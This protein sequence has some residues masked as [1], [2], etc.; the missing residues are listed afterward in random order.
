MTMP[1]VDLQQITKKWHISQI[2]VFL[3]NSE[4]LESVDIDTLQYKDGNP[5]SEKSL[6]NLPRIGN[7]RKMAIS[8]FLVPIFKITG[9]VA[10]QISVT[11]GSN[12]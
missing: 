10:R 4:I 8:R 2:S 5:S 11:N 6:N 12:L 7:N 1:R 9:I 3:P